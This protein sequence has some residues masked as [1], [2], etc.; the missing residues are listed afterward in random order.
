MVTIKKKHRV[1]VDLSETQHDRVRTDA[2]D[3]KKTVK[4]VLEELIEK[5][6]KK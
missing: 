6:Y 2:F 1:S 5:K 4:K 3:K